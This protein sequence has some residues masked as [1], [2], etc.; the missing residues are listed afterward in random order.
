MQNKRY[1]LVWE[2]VSTT[3]RNIYK[4]LRRFM[5]IFFS[6]FFFSFFV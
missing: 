2:E 1:L 4:K 3:R 6:F 5:W